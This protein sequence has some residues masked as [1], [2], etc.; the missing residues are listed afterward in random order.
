MQKMPAFFVVV[1]LCALSA[2]ESNE[3]A[4]A[5]PPKK[6]MSA[7]QLETEADKLGYAIGASAAETLKAM[8]E[9]GIQFSLEAYFEA[10]RDVLAGRR[11]A[12][13]SDEVHLR[14]RELRLAARMRGLEMAEERAEAARKN[15]AEGEAFLAR[16]AKRSGVVVLDSG[17][18]YEILEE[19]TGARPTATD[20][21]RVHYRGTLIDGIEFDNSRKHGPGPAEFAVGGSIIA[22]WREALKR[23]KEGAKWRVFVPPHLAYGG[24]SRG[25]IPPNATLIFEIELVEIA[26]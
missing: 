8:R 11:P 21:V 20:K 10:I 12:L 18:Q 14:M 19:G 9:D 7:A 15:K 5:T 23:M 1:A 25:K 4:S 24:L 22:G 13:S 17:L 26:E 16:N 2:A 3:K 6:E